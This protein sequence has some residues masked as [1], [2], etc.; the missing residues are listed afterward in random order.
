MFLQCRKQR[1]KACCSADSTTKACFRA[2]TAVLH[3]RHGSVRE[4]AAIV[5]RQMT[6]NIL[7]HGD[8]ASKA[9]AQ[10]TSNAKQT[11][12]VRSHALAFVRDIVRYCCS[13]LFDG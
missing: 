8:A 6:S 4:L 13:G 11:A 2:L 5:L 3:T 12:A 1:M 9:T 10:G 7:G